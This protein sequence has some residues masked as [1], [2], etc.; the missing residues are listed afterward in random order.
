MTVFQEPEALG[1]LMWSSAFL[2]TVF[3]QCP[4]RLPTG[5]VRTMLYFHRD[6]NE[7]CVEKEISAANT[8]LKIFMLNFILCVACV[9]SFSLSRFSLS[10]WGIVVELYG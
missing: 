1:R 3:L 8:L 5:L 6:C 2:D 9:D 10:T 4:T 7:S